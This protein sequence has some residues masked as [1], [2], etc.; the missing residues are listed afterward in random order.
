MKMRLFILLMLALVGCTSQSKKKLADQQADASY[1]LQVDSTFLAD[2]STAGLDEFPAPAGFKIADDESAYAI[3]REQLIFYQYNS[4]NLGSPHCVVL[5]TGFPG[6]FELD[7]ELRFVY[8]ATLD[9]NAQVLD[10]TQIG[11]L[12]EGSDSSYLLTATIEGNQVL[13]KFRY[14]QFYPEEK[15]DSGYETLVIHRS[16]EIGPPK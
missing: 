14:Q 7:G 12:E 4:F 13:K 11:R 2:Y 3:V 10:V 1:S 15:T 5:V 9:E 8:L 6:D 16:G